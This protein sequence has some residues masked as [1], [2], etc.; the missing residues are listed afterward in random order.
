MRL[1]S[2]ATNERCLKVIIKALF[3][4]DVVEVFPAMMVFPIYSQKMLPLW[5]ILLLS[6]DVSRYFK[7]L[8][9]RIHEVSQRYRRQFIPSCMKKV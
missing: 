6:S 5:P 3:R 7:K 1:K 9:E 2:N 8:Y 4:K